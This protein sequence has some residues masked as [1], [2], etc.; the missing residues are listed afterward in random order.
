MTKVKSVEFT[1]EQIN[2]LK[3]DPILLM[4]T[5]KETKSPELLVAI[6]E[7]VMANQ[8]PT[9]EAPVQVVTE[10]Q[11][12][13]DGLVFVD[14]RNNEYVLRVTGPCEIHL[15]Q[16]V[17]WDKET[18]GLLKGSW[19]KMEVFKGL[20]EAAKLAKAYL[21]GKNKKGFMYAAHLKI[22]DAK[23]PQLETVIAE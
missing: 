21:F 14:L 16:I 17:S 12:P 10:V 7:L 15:N 20:D 5:Y 9:K 11:K 6:Q 19:L 2:K 8:Q 1:V 23:K 3:M 22:E 4:A 13:K 18:R